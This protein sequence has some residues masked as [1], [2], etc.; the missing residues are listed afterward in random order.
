MA[1]IIILSTGKP[2]IRK[3]ELR[4]PEVEAQASPSTEHVRV[5]TS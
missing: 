5:S 2:L 4:E 1:G 3:L